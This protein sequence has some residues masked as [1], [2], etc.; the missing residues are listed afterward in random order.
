MRDK[1]AS[2]KQ[3]AC[4]ACTRPWLLSPALRT[5]RT[6]TLGVRK[7]R[8][9]CGQAWWPTPLTQHLGSRG[10]QSSVSW[11][12]ACSIDRVL[13][14]TGIH[15]K[16][17]SPKIK[18]EQANSNK[19]ALGVNT[20]EALHESQ[21]LNKSTTKTIQKNTDIGLCPGQPVRQKENGLPVQM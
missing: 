9:K 12:A 7:Q 4:L 1:D 8:W 5:N 3:T 18:T 20:W 2:L 10:R 15:S 19:P 17:Q 21:K 16:T 6:N 13:G 14:Q 11:R